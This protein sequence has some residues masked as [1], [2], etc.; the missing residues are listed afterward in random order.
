MITSRNEE[1]WYWEPE[2][3]NEVDLYNF[4]A[5]S[6]FI[7]T[8]RMHGIFIAAMMGIPVVGISLHPKLNYASE[9]FGESVNIVSANPTSD[10]LIKAYHKSIS[11]SSNEAII[12]ENAI[13]SVNGVYEQINVWI[14]K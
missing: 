8:S 13:S 11:A 10:E 3:M 4:F 9:L 14:Q 12:L 1:T 2:Q 7:V 5:T 6:Q